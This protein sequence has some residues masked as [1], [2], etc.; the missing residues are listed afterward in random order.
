MVLMLIDKRPIGIDHK[1]GVIGEVRVGVTP[2]ER[3]G[4]VVPFFQQL[5]AA[6][7]ELRLR[8]AVALSDLAV[9][10]VYFRTIAAAR[11]EYQCRVEE[12]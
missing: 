9:V 2:N 7:E 4:D 6:V 10:P 8:E 5:G 11:D 12:I 3:V 1:H